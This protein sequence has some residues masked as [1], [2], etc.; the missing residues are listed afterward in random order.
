MA[1]KTTYLK[2]AMLNHV[3]GNTAHTAA[4]THYIGLYTDTGTPASHNA[5]TFTEPSLNVWTNYARLSK[6]NNTTNWSNATSAPVYKKNAVDFAFPAATISAGTI[7]L[8]GWF[9]ADAATGGNILAWTP[10]VGSAKVATVDGTSDTFTSPAH[11]LLNDDIVYLESLAYA[12]FPGGV[13]DGSYYYVV[14]KATD[15]FQV[16]ATLGGAAINVASGVCTAALTGSFT[17]ATGQV[18]TIATNGIVLAE[19]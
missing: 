4:A 17:V 13:T 1:F 3:F 10:F 8:Y 16:S 7:T 5:G 2:Q 9:V 15:T 11:G 6:T 12:S 19:N 14:N 18:V